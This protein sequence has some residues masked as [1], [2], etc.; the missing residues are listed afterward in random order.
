MWRRWQTPQIRASQVPGNISLAQPMRPIMGIRT[1]YWVWF[2][3]SHI[4]AWVNSSQACE[5]DYR[6]HL[7][8][9]SL[10]L[11]WP[12]LG[13]APGWPTLWTKGRL[14]Q[15]ER[16]ENSIEKYKRIPWNNLILNISSQWDH[17]TIL[18]LVDSVVNDDS[19]VLIFLSG[20]K[21]EGVPK[22][23]SAK[24]ELFKVGQLVVLSSILWG[25]GHMRS[26]L[27]FWT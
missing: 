18:D 21:R 24:D 1:N 17:F 14:I 27:H 2:I 25:T 15:I 26:K 3:G 8:I 22:H 5:T 6:I 9:A 16:R 12:A 11:C 10:Q 23:F 7:A 4:W 13:W 19:W 20:R